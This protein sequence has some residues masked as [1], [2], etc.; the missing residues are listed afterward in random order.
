MFLYAADAR[1][2][3]SNRIVEGS[4]ES[5]QIKNL[6]A[7]CVLW[8]PDQ[9][10]TCKSETTRF[11]IEIKRPAVD[12]AAICTFE[13]DASRGVSFSRLWSGEFGI[14]YATDPCV[15]V[16]SQAKLA[17]R[18]LKHDVR[19][20]KL[21]A[22]ST[23]QISLEEGGS[24][25]L[26]FQPHLSFAT[27]RPEHPKLSS[28]E[29]TL[30][31]VRRLVTESVRRLAKPNTAHLLSGGIDSSIIAAVALSVGCPL[32]TFTFA[33]RR[34]PRPESGSGSDVVAARGVAKWLG[35]PHRVIEVDR[36]RLSKNIPLAIYLAETSRGTIVDELVAHI[37]VAR[38][39]A[40][41][42]IDRILT[43]AG[44]DDLFGAFPF[45][46]R[47]FRG[48]QLRAHLQEA[49][50]GA[51]PDELAL[52]QSIYSAWGISL[53][54]PYWTKDLRTIGYHLPLRY[55]IDRQR[56]M[57]RVLRDAFAGLLPPAIL[58]RPK[59]VPRDCSQI[60]HVLEQEF[61]RSPHRYRAIFHKMMLRGSRWQP[62]LNPPP[63][64]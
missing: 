21:A 20:Q 27:R 30:R 49:L 12:D 63:C 40:D 46:L 47:Y 2:V 5:F 37:E 28:Y 15:I 48:L 7:G 43:G 41:E 57:K 18:M 62:K 6:S 31:K 13:W 9:F 29:E 54:H 16:A 36:A 4:F 51:L 26:T 64:G 50:L 14:L 32:R 10:T 17:V 8:L 34:P 22:G 53:V 19:L 60:R 1:L 59:G 39:L 23:A 24:R 35:I 3:N 58:E 38:I 56:L 25:T 11:R 61:G 42:G 33:M 52:M 55:R 45:A 44:A